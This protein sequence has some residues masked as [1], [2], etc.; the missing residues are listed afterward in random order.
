[1]KTIHFVAGLP[2]SGSSLLCNI[3]MQ[4]PAIYASG[5]SGLP[6]V[7]RGI[8]DGWDL[9][10]PFRAMTAA[11]SRAAL[12]GTLRGALYGYYERVDGAGRPFCDRPVVLDR[13]RGW[14]AYIEMLEAM[15]LGGPHATEKHDV[16][17]LCCV[18][19]MRDIV[20]S[21]E[22]R[23]RATIATGLTTQ[24]RTEGATFRT[25]QGRCD[26]WVRGD[27]PIGSAFNVLRD[28]VDRGHRQRLHFI[29]YEDLT[30]QPAATMAGIY[31]FLGLEQYEHDF[32]QVEQQ[33]H[34]DD[35]AHG[36]VGLHDIATSVEARPAR[37][38]AVLG[39]M[40]DRYKGQE[41]W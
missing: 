34:E 24:K 38:P 28:A 40:G 26:L 8:R 18:R 10:S 17:M 16:K 25:M 11:E 33:I 32:N 23:H 2:R 7:L 29:R 4:N 39:P 15:G 35:R 30:A 31:A 5:T 22:L 37:W 20:A 12:L 14:P 1:M 13:S 3:L 27:Q 6:E 41:F 21:F 19:D 9:A 36:F